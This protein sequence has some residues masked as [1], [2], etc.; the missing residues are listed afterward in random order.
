M[1]K[2]NDGVNGP[3]AWGNGPQP[4]KKGLISKIIDWA[5][6]QGTDKPKK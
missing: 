2:E 6:K 3:Y 4:K 5:T 1:G